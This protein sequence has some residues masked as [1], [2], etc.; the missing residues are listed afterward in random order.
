[1]L[2][3]QTAHFLPKKCEQVAQTASRS[4]LATSD[5]IF[6][7]DFRTFPVASIVILSFCIKRPDPIF[8]LCT[9]IN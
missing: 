7:P 2:Q 8:T 4:A 9:I 6:M 1:M 3:P 5:V